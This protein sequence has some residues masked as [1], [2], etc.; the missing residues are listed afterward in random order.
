LA[1]IFVSRGF[2]VFWKYSNSGEAYFY[3]GARLYPLNQKWF[4]QLFF[5]LLLAVFVPLIL[6]Y[7]VLAY[8]P[9]AIVVVL[10]A[11]IFL[12]VIVRSYRRWCIE[13]KREG[14]AGSGVSE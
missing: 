9:Y 11:A 4:W 5:A 10:L 2:V 13:K 14:E 6:F 8:A 3:C 7:V 1:F 12:W